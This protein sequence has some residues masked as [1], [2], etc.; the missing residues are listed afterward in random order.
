[1]VEGKGLGFEVRCFGFE[2]QL[3]QVL[4][5]DLNMFLKPLDLS[6]DNI[7]YLLGSCKDYMTCLVQ[8]LTN[9]FYKRPNTKFLGSLS[10]DASVTTTQLYHHGMKAA[11][12]NK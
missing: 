8:R 4:V 5:H 2:P 12:D 11:I 3:Y 9:L 7:I 10:H 1:M 6:T